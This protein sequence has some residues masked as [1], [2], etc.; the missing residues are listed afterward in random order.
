MV[1][2]KI[3]EFLEKEERELKGAQID[4]V[5]N[6]FASSTHFFSKGYDLIIVNQK[7]RVL[8]DVNQRLIDTNPDVL[9]FFPFAKKEKIDSSTLMLAKAAESYYT[10]TN[11]ASLLS[12]CSE[13][14][15]LENKAVMANYP[16]EKKQRTL[17]ELRKKQRDLF[18]LACDSVCC[19][20]FK[21]NM[22]YV[23]QSDVDNLEN[24]KF[25]LAI[26][27]QAELES[28]INEI[29]EH[30]QE[31]IWCLVRKKRIHNYAN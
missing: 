25:C 23:F 19:D 3:L 10:A 15:K 21:T 5:S 11:V 14:Q 20:A 1:E 27:Y 12:L 6:I 31:D 17:I 7:M 29:L 4:I 28:K 18:K 16:S 24:M 2:Q 26:V 9:K 22:P 30:E 13:Y 8:N